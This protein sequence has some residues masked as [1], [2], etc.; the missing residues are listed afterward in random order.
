M[1][2][3]FLAPVVS[4]VKS[5]PEAVCRGLAGVGA[6]VAIAGHNGEKAR[7]L[8]DDMGDGA[9]AAAFDAASVEQIRAMV[10]RRYTAPAQAS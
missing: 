10:E 4:T 9:Y 7:A 1:S 3:N 6:R 5:A 8:A 2:A